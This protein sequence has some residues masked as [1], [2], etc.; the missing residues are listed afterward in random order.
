MKFVLTDLSSGSPDRRRKKKKSIIVEASD[1][2][3][4]GEL[5]ACL[6]EA[7]SSKQNGTNNAGG[8]RRDGGLIEWNAAENKAICLGWGG[9]KGVTIDGGGTRTRVAR[10]FQ[11]QILDTLCQFRHICGASG[12]AGKSRRRLHSAY[13]K[14][15]FPPHFFVL[16]M[17]AAS[18]SPRVSR[19]VGGRCVG[20]SPTVSTRLSCTCHRKSASPSQRA[21]GNWRAT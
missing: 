11:T 15:P 5:L 6:A 16:L 12:A 14:R 2:P 9:G 7:A 8:E 3:I 4:N 17:L 13:F 21:L 1:G 20:G 19:G 10:G 18:G